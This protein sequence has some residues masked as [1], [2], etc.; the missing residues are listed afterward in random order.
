VVSSNE[1]D[2]ER[3]ELVD[4]EVVDIV[5]VIHVLVPTAEVCVTVVGAV[6]LCNGILDRSG[7]IWGFSLVESLRD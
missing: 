7:N 6:G 5:G 2:M 3:Q 1:K 4:G